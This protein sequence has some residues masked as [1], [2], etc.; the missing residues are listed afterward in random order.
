MH[1]RPSVDGAVPLHQVLNDDLDRLRR[2]RAREVTRVS[3][4][5]TMQRDDME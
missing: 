1:V 2:E 4:T 3:D 5:A